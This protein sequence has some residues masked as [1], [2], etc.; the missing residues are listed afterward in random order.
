MKTIRDIKP[1][2]YYDGVQV[3]EARD[4]IGGHYVGVMIETNGSTG[5]YL[6][7]GAAPEA[8]RRFRLGK[9]D[10]RSLLLESPDDEWYLTQVGDDFRQP[11]S[12]ERRSDRL[13]DAAFLPAPGFTLDE[14]PSDDWVL[15]EAYGRGNVIFEFS[16]DPPEA[17]SEHRMRAATLGGLLLYVQTLV[18]HAYRRAVRDLPDQT[19]RVLDFADGG[20]MNVVIPAAPG[21]F[22]VVCEAARPT[23]MF[24]SGELARGL[25]RMDAVFE[26]AGSPKTAKEGLNSHKGHLAGSYINLVRFLGEN[27][28]NLQY[29]WAEP[30]STSAHRGGVSEVVAR[31][32]AELL[33][34]IDNL[35]TESVTFVGA[36]ERAQRDTGNWSLVTQEGR[37][38]GT[39]VEGEPTLNGL[40]VGRKYRFDCE[41]HLAIAASGRETRTYYL[42][43]ISDAG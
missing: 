6:V 22:R 38:S 32:L 31:E 9:L 11:L 1:L 37:I 43:A 19:K 26:G 13:A 16:A 3:F 40:E 21:S 2:V 5:Q 30:A 10:L 34:G 42:R 39:T 33:A 12:L 28:M 35:S 14:P 17:A 23:D 18:M 41:E 20:L 8:I 27:G 29:S 36:L 4:L 15:Q 24:G 7:A 25:L